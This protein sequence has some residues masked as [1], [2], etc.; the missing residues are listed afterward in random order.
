MD[1][2]NKLKYHKSDAYLS[3]IAKNH[4]QLLKNNYFYPNNISSAINKKYNL[5]L[6]PNSPKMTVSKL[7]KNINAPL[8]KDITINVKSNLESGKVPQKK[9]NTS[10]SLNKTPKNHTNLTI[11][12]NNNLGLS[13]DQSRMNRSGNPQS[14][15]SRVK[16]PTGKISTSRPNLKTEL[17]YNSAADK[18]FYNDACESGKKN[19]ATISIKLSSPDRYNYNNQLKRNLA[20]PTQNLNNGNSFSKAIISNE[21]KPSETILTELIDSH[22]SGNSPVRKKMANVDV[23]KLEDNKSGRKEK[24][25]GDDDK[26]I[27]LSFTGEIA[28]E[29]LLESLEAFKYVYEQEF[30]NALVREKCQKCLEALSDKRKSVRFDE[31]YI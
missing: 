3:P 31:F 26:T 30:E 13:N 7:V 12:T 2:C 11:N 21:K 23:S 25:N 27:N 24:Q 20:S 1:K 16:S 15:Y 18:K 19:L 4:N 28:H 22:Y 9:V 8:K 14:S 17:D 6:K 29:T 10:L 5:P